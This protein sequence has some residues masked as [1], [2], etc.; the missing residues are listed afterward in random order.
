VILIPVTDPLGEVSAPEELNV[1]E[2]EATMVGLVAPVAD[3]GKVM[4]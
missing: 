4:L 2:P 1:S 3:A